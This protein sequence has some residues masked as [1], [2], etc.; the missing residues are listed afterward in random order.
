MTTMTTTPAALL[1]CVNWNGRQITRLVLG[2]NPMKGWSHCTPE[3][4]A[5]MK[6]W[7]NPAD[8]H[9]LEIMRR[10][11]ACGINTCQFGGPPMHDRLRRH[12]AE[13]GHLQWIATLYDSGSNWNP[14]AP[15]FEEELTQILAMDPKPIGIQNFGE[16]SDRYFITGHM[17]KLR[18]K[19]KRFRDTGLLVGVCTHLPEVVEHIETQG[20]DVDFYQ[21]CLYTVYSLVNEKRIDRTREIYDDAARERMLGFVQ[22]T[23]KPCMVFKALKA[24]RF[25]SSD[26]EVRETL[27]YTYNHIKP[28]DAVCVGM[29]DK[30]KDQV[31]Q[32]T[33][34]VREILAAKTAR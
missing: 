18:E 24:N 19:L 34:F 32:N 10:A 4:D 8:G 28:I 23:R 29:W 15:S 14:D 30:Y 33:R 12:A 11:Q 31:G 1:P 6:A 3:L 5:E 22:R 7:F 21:T 16:N 17:D 26:Q 9:D 2:H 25:C 27:Q 13:G 20:W